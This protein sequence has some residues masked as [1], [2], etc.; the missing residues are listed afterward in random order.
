MKGV[1]DRFEEKQAVILMEENNTE[2][3][4][5]WHSLPAGSDVNTWFDIEQSGEQYHLTIDPEKTAQEAQ[6]SADLVAELRAKSRGSQFK[7][8]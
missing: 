1:L 8:K 5:D 3:I 4:I 7:K 2:I 6:T